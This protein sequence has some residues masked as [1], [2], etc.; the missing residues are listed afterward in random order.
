MK[1]VERVKREEWLC[2]VWFWLAE[3]EEGVSEEKEEVKWRKERE[4]INR[5]V[6]G[7][8][9]KWRE[10]KRVVRGTRL[11]ASPCPYNTVS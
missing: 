8:L 1:R 11:H 3:E 4:W 10:G 6:E 5:A 2:L 7:I 9:E